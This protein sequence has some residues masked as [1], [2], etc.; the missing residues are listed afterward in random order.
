MFI[1]LVGPDGAG[2]TTLAKELAAESKRRHLDF[3]YLHWLPL[4]GAIPDE[5]IE[6]DCPP[7]KLSKPAGPQALQFPI[8]LL[9]LARNVVRFWMRYL[10]VMRREMPHLHSGRAL[11][12]G[13]RWIYNYVGQPL[14]VGYSGPRWVARWAMMLAP[15]PDLVVVLHAPPAVIV[16]RKAELS[17]HEVVTELRRWSSLPPV[18]PILELDATPAPADLVKAIFEAP[19]LEPLC[20]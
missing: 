18:A 9:R 4:K 1:V 20:L 14:S 8:S 10:F 11:V 19:T 15:R 3:G 5:V 17:E 12:V 7:P 6:N 13:D 2:K 16:G